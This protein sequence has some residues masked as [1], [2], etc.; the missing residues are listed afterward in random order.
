MNRLDRHAAVKDLQMTWSDTQV[1]IFHRTVRQTNLF[2][3]QSSGYEIWQWLPYALYAKI[4]ETNVRVL[5]NK[6]NAKSYLKC[7]TSDY[8]MYWAWFPSEIK[9]AT[10]NLKTRP[11]ISGFAGSVKFS[12]GMPVIV[13]GPIKCLRR[14]KLTWLT[15]SVLDGQHH[16]IK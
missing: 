3:R 5:K 11:E 10:R 4:C 6:I 15:P 8:W 16:L 12:C 9:G 13:L 7:Y 2:M 14:Y 1:Y